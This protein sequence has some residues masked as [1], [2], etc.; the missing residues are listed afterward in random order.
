LQSR[1]YLYAHTDSDRLAH[2]KIRELEVDLATRGIKK[3]AEINQ[4]TYRRLTLSNYREEVL[5]LVYHGQ[6]GLRVVPQGKPGS[7]LLKTVQEV[8]DQ[9]FGARSAPQGELVEPMERLRQTYKVRDANSQQR[10]EKYVFARGDAIREPEKNCTYRAKIVKGNKTVFVRQFISGTLTVDG[11]E[12][13]YSE[14]E[15]GIRAILGVSD[16]GNGGGSQ[17]HHQEQVR[18][19]ESVEL[20][21]MWV[22]SDEAGKGDYFGP[23]V[24]AAVLVDK[25]LA[26]VLEALGVKDSKNLSDK[27]NRELAVQI[28]ESLGKRAQ[29]IM[30]PPVRYNQLFEEFRRED[31]NLNTLLAWAHTRALENILIAFPHERLSVL[32]DK[33]ADEGQ[34]LNKL[35]PEG[36]RANLNIVQM[37]KAEANVAVAAASIL[38]RAR[39]LHAL[40][41]LS[42]Q[43]QID[44]PK[45]AS[46]PRIPEVG[47][48]IVERWGRNELT[49]VAKLHFKTTEKILGR[50]TL[51]S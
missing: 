28:A 47:R 20:G 24:S 14:V 5:L 36:R 15:E 21:E 40:D 49:K 11:D 33:F 4:A 50:A 9:V 27:R 43:Y 37:P 35:L 19:V 31:K 18:A 39:F 23:L 13:L 26:Q 7:S 16:S 46:D 25:H 8:S 30:I 34:I 10:I 2:A 12:P 38:A 29:V 17:N 22:G 6:K 32:V 45:G 48:Q 42:K 44:F 51:S 41:A 3:V 1:S